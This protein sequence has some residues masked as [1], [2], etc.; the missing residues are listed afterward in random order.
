MEKG[1]ISWVFISCVAY[2][3]DSAERQCALA[4][5][6]MLVGA[7]C[8]GI[9]AARVWVGDAKVDCGVA[10]IVGSSAVGK[11]PEVGYG[12]EIAELPSSAGRTMTEGSSEA[13][14]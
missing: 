4:Q 1:E 8:L 13:S 10:G 2:R 3:G 6:D 12:E 5:L 11:P 14:G 7:T 9:A